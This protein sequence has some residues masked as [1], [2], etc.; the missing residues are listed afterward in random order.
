MRAYIRHAVV[1]A[2]VLSLALV[3]CS[4]ESDSGGSS[5]NKP[6]VEAS[7]DPAEAPAE[8]PPSSAPAAEVPVVKVGETKTWDYGETDEYGENYKVTSKMS[9]TVVSAKYVTPAEIDTTN[10]PEQGQ[11]VELELTLKNVGQAPAEVM[12]YG[13]LKWE[14]A[15]HAAQ[16]ATTL[17]GV[18]DGPELDTSYK[19]GQAVT[20]KVV[21]DVATK[22]GKVSYTGTE[23]PEAEAAFIVELPSS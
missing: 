21:L 13:M 12:L 14:D 6:A 9:V 5:K 20:G 11:F 7:V 1:P 3:G 23:D 19:P 15:D 8:E 17:E 2:V 10:E 22:G 4:S 18:G 16:D